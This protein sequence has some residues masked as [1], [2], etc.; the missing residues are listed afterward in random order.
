MLAVSAGCAEGDEVGSGGNGGT[1]GGSSTKS[2]TGAGGEGGGDCIPGTEICDGKDNDCDEQIDEVPGGCDCNDGE[3]RACYSGR[4]SSQGV[5]ECE[6]GTQTCEDGAWG[7]CAGEVIPVMEACNGLDDDCNGTPDDMGTTSCGIGA[8]MATVE[9]CVGGQTQ[10]CVPGQPSLE[11]CDGVDNNCNQLTDE[12]DPLVGAACSTGL[13]GVCQPGVNVCQNGAIACMQ[14]QL[15]GTEQCDDLD[16]DCDGTPDDNVPGTG[17]A[18]NTGAPGVC[19]PGTV[20]CQNGSVDCYSNVA[21]SAEACDTLDNDCDGQVDEGNPGGGGSCATGLPGACAVGTLNCQAGSLSCTPNAQAQPEVCDGA[22]NNC[23]G[24]SDEGNPGGGQ[25]CSCGGTSACN[26]G[27]ILCQGCTKEVTCNNGVDDEGDGF[28]DCADSQC[29]LGC[30]ALVGPCAAG[31]QLLVLSST[32]VPK[33]IN[34]NSTV[35]SVITFSEARTVNRVV[36]QLNI[37]HTYDSDLAITLRAPDLTSVDLSSNN[38]IGG[39][40]YTNTIFKDGCAAVTGGVAPFNGC[41]GP[42]QAL[43]TMAGKQLQG[44]WTLSIADQ[45]TIDTGSLTAWTLAMCVSP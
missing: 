22:D 26:S 27:Q 18:C 2:T 33:T 24:Q 7:A 38:G 41:Y 14:N 40:N 25:A 42:E 15:A 31:Q 17:G 4:P 23:N 11:V 12:T 44:T 8:C 37:N 21:S 36:L 10:Q 30:N 6:G 29:A 3:T 28:I 9:V 32:D 34:D 43:S 19:G 39:D 1:G 20:S 13:L 5:G 45:F 35:S 16:N